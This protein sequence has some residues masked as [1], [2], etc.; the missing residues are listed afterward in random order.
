ME[1]GSSCD[2]SGVKAR[3]RHIICPEDFSGVIVSTVS[4]TALLS[5]PTEGCL[6]G[7]SRGIRVQLEHLLF[8]QREEEEVLFDSLVASEPR[9][10]VSLG[11]IVV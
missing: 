3:L 8:H 11:F 7:T 10:R 4:N 1:A 5:L 2:C 6:R 9:H